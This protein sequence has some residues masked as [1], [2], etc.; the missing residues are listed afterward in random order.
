MYMYDIYIQAILLKLDIQ[1]SKH[2]NIAIAKT[3][4]ENFHSKGW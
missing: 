3:W 1:I 4:Y 2:Y